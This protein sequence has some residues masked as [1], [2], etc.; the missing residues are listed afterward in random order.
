MINTQVRPQ[1]IPKVPKAKTSAAKPS[2]KKKAAPKKAA[3][4]KTTKTAKPK[5]S[6]KGKVAIQP[7]HKKSTP[8]ANKRVRE[9]KRGESPFSSPLAGDIVRGDG[10]TRT[11]L[12]VFT[13]DLS[14]GPAHKVEYESDAGRTRTV[15][16]ASWAQWCSRYQAELVSRAPAPAPA[17]ADTEPAP[18]GDIV[19]SPQPEPDVHQAE[20]IDGQL[21]AQKAQQ[22]NVPR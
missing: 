20:Y 14:S 15:N 22:E 13:K 17:T 8:V 10:E 18:I 4:K 9:Y 11:V 3:P 16:R 6:A 2:T 19:P 21:K 1:E 7:V 5:A 12:N